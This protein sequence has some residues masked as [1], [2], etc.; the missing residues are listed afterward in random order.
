MSFF[1]HAQNTLVQGDITATQ[2]NGNIYNDEVTNIA[3][4]QNNYHGALLKGERTGSV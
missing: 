2:V 4:I 1:N 3:S